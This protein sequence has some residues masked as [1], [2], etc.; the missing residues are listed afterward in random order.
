[1]IDPARIILTGGHDSR[2]QWEYRCA[3][4]LAEH[5]GRPLH[6]LPGGHNGLTTHP[7]AITRAVRT[8]V[9]EVA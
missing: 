7:W 6:E 9:Q 3:Q 5:L 4:T 2:G 8:W 1:M